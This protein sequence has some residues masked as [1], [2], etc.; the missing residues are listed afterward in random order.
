MKKILTLITLTVLLFTG[1]AIPNYQ[2]DL[3]LARQPI[4][5][6]DDNLREI[7]I[8]HIKRGGNS[9]NLNN[10]DVSNVTNMRY[11]FAHSQFNGD[12]SS[13]DVSN[14]TDMSKMFLN[15]YFRGDISSWDVS[16]VTNMDGMFGISRFNRDISGWDVSN[17]TNMRIMFFRAAGFT[18]DISNWDVSNV[19]NMRGMFEESQFNND[20]SKWDVS[21]V[22][23]MKEMF[24]NSKFNGDISKWWEYRDRSDTNTDDMFDKS[25]SFSMGIFLGSMYWGYSVSDLLIGVFGVLIL[26]ISWVFR[27]R[28]WSGV[29]REKDQ[30]IG[31]KDN[32]DVL[33]AFPTPALALTPHLATVIVVTPFLITVFGT[34]KNISDST[35]DISFM[36]IFFLILSALFTNPKN[37]NIAKVTSLMGAIFIVSFMAVSALFTTVSVMSVV[38]TLVISFLVSIFG[39]GYVNDRHTQYI[40]VKENKPYAR[41]FWKTAQDLYSD[42]KTDLPKQINQK[43]KVRSGADHDTALEITSELKYSKKWVNHVYRIRDAHKEE[44]I[45]NMNRDIAAGDTGDWYEYV[46]GTAIFAK[47]GDEKSVCIIRILQEEGGVYDEKES[48]WISKLLYMPLVTK[49]SNILWLGNEAIIYSHKHKVAWGIGYEHQIPDCKKDLE[50]FNKQQIN[51]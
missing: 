31:G 37:V 29:D 34:D 47:Q 19:T 43:A 27:N 44:D 24:K 46:S 10:I 23:S 17:V 40:L 5:A 13:W 42:I 22:T 12:I 2:E 48:A 11:M 6:N 39:G 45:R 3:R 26:V 33:I 32:K 15:S 51:E 28:W 20:I 16:K 18:G 30:Y 4:V 8:D 9:V 50:L 38:F 36:I 1:Q 21:N 7:L 25:I 41:R 14:V 35:F 49:F